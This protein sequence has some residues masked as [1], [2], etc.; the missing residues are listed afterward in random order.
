MIYDVMPIYPWEPVAF[1]GCGKKNLQQKSSRRS[2]L[3]SFQDFKTL[4]QVVVG[5]CKIET[6]H[7]I[8]NK[9]MVIE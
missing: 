1:T 5:L 4:F 8:V 6:H 9:I 2:C 7:M 3:E